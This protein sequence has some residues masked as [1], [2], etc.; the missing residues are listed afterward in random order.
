M[1]VGVGV[2]SG[3]GKINNFENS[4]SGGNTFRE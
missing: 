4:V 2:G 1:K 3:F